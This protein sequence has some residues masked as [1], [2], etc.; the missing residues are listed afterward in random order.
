MSLRQVHC[1]RYPHTNTTSDQRN[2]F[3]FSSAEFAFPQRQTNTL[4]TLSVRPREGHRGGLCQ[5]SHCRV[6]GYFSRMESVDSTCPWQNQGRSQRAV[7]DAIPKNLLL[8]LSPPTKLKP[9]GDWHPAYYSSPVSQS[10][11]SKNFGQCRPGLSLISNPCS[12]H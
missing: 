11:D 7:E 9:S 3:F 5:D 12:L 6:H 8:P 4:L 2:G 1:K 10:P